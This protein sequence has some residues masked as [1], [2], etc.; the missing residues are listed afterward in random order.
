MPKI[1]LTL[2]AISSLAACNTV[3]GFGQDVQKTGQAIEAEAD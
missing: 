2:I 3:E 1:I